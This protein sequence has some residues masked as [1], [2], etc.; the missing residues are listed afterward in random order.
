MRATLEAVL[1]VS[2][3]GKVFH[4]R[5]QRTITIQACTTR[6]WWFCECCE[7]QRQLP[8]LDDR[9][10]RFQCA[11]IALLRLSAE[12]LDCTRIAREE[13]ELNL[14][15]Q[16][17]NC[18]TTHECSCEL[19]QTFPGFFL[20]RIVIGIHRHVCSDVIDHAL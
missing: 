18:E 1:K 17:Y 13:R 8:V 7:V 19:L 3:H 14:G 9:F 15:L 20:S 11:Q 6:H 2:M 10:Q 12:L 5:F 4:R 16:V